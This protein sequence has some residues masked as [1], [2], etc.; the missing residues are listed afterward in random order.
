[1]NL[2]RVLYGAAGLMLASAVAFAGQADPKLEKL[3]NPAS[4]T[5][6][7]P[8]TYKAKFDTSKGAI[9]ITVHRD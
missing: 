3:K 4:F 2:T 5:E 1:M 9:V 7:A 6:K 8:A